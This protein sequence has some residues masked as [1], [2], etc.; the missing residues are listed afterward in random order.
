MKILK[1]ILLIITILG[2]LFLLYYYYGE[3]Y[4]VNYNNKQE[5]TSLIS[6]KKQHNNGIIIIPSINKKEM[7]YYNDIENNLKNKKIVILSDLISNNN[8]F[9]KYNS[10][11]SPNFI[12]GAHNYNRGNL[13][14]TNLNKV[15][16]N[17]IITIIYNNITYKY[18]VVS[19]NKTNTRLDKSILKIDEYNDYL[20]I[21]SCLNNQEI[22]ESAYVDY[23]MLKAIKLK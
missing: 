15:K 14:L 4:L 5:V 6:S 18:K 2:G 1:C 17:D 12:I 20:T 11:K 9:D 19:N 21:L 13:G 3:S 7:I 8:E 10:P 23:Q 16:I 22:T